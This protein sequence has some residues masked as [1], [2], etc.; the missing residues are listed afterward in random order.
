MKRRSWKSE[1]NFPP[2]FPVS[3]R[4]AALFC[5]SSLLAFSATSCGLVEMRDAT[6]EVLTRAET[7][8]P[9]LQQA[10][11]YSVVESVGETETMPETEAAVEE[12]PAMHVALAVAGG[13]RIDDAILSDAASRAAEGK[14]YSFLTMYANIFPVIQ[15]ADMTMVTLQDPVGD[16]TGAMPMDSLTALT[17]L[18]FDVINV[19]GT[20]R[21]ENAGAGLH[22]TVDNVCTH[23]V[24]E[25]GAY[26]DDI[27]AGDV[28]VL[29]QD[30]VRVAYVSFTEN[31]DTDT[32]GL[33]LHD[34]TDAA[35]VSAI[36]TYADLVSDV[37]VV[38][39]TWD[40]GTDSTVRAE[41][42]SACQLLA[43]A[44]ADIIVGNDGRGLQT[45]EWLTA[46]DGTQT[47]AVYSLGD[48]LSTGSDAQTT[49]SGVLTLDVVM[50]EAGET[51]LEDVQ[52][53]PVVKHYTAE[54]GYQV[55]ELTKYTAD[56][57]ALHG[58]GNITVDALQSVVNG[59]L[60]AAFLPTN[61]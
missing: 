43:E 17:D 41:Q 14:D 11:R 60:P 39:V 49:L 29:E 56:T 53:L 20:D 16:G 59:T 30:G 50:N 58:L 33:I 45:A 15:N 31:A 42:R 27:D 7:T 18:G 9:T 19:A 57:A 47:L 40:N 12:E 3:K 38:S 25:I 4:L 54:G 28:R 55:T 13:V 21:L 2:I 36:V 32:D 8:A 52:I 22:T 24:L 34:L 1:S 44:G 5:V 46:E 26:K 10:E 61:N 23:D 51:T 37:V 35:N 48:L 6:S